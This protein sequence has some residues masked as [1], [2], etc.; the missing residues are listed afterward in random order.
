MPAPALL[1]GLE[2]CRLS[3]DQAD[4]LGT[5]L[6][7]IEAGGWA[8]SVYEGPALQPL[9]GLGLGPVE[10]ALAPALVTRREVATSSDGREGTLRVLQGRV[11]VRALFAQGPA[12]LG[13]DAAWSSGRA[14]LDGDPVASGTPALELG[15]TLGLN[16]PVAA[17]WSLTTRARYPFLLREGSFSGGVDGAVSLDWRPGASP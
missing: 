10:L 4:A 14:T 17:A 9:V 16:L 6:S 5:S 8:L 12:R 13:L 2:L 15:P 3:S 1:L 7:A 11:G